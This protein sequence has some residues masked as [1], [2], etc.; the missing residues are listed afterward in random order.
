MF[1]HFLHVRIG[2]VDLT[3]GTLSPSSSS[4]PTV[5]DRLY[6]SGVISTNSIGVSFEPATSTSD[7]NGELTWGKFGVLPSQ[8]TPVLNDSPL[9][10]GGINSSKLTGSITYVYT[11]FRISSS[12]CRYTYCAHPARSRPLPPRTSTGVSLSQSLTAAPAPRSCPPPQ[13]SS[14]P[15]R[16]RSSK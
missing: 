14:I 2:P 10:L 4:I 11:G 5:T 13:E 1:N 15:V 8:R 7:A 16:S 12:S 6:S 9:I 3:A